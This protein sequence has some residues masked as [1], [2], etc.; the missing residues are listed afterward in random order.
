MKRRDILMVMVIPLI[1][2]FSNVATATNGEGCGPGYW[3]QSQHFDSWDGTLCTAMDTATVAFYAVCPETGFPETGFEGPIV[4]DPPSVELCLL[5]VEK[6]VFPD[7][8]DCIDSGTDDGTD[9]DGDNDCICDC[10]DSGTDTGTNGDNFCIVDKVMYTY[11]ITN[12]GDV[13]L[14]DV[15]VFDDQ[16]GIIAEFM[17]LEPGA[18]KILTIEDVCLCEET[19]NKVTVTGTLQYTPGTQFSA[20]FEMHSLEKHCMTC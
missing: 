10:V 17:E 18:E 12:T 3:K 20:V 19:T 4:S 2:T 6:E 9:G 15:T 16:L 8:I 5:E 7:T 11:T 13:A 1:L 14:K